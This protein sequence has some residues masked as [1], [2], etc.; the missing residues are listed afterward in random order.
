MILDTDPSVVAKTNTF[1]FIVSWAKNVSVV[2]EA[3]TNLSDPVWIPLRTNAITDG[4][5]R[6]SE[7]VRTN[8]SGHFYRVRRR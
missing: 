2:V 6:F 7:P 5:F 1:S 8:I 3:C 4:Y